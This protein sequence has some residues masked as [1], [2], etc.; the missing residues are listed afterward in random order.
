M[1]LDA[2][3]T[4]LPPNIQSLEYL[5][6]VNL[7]CFHSTKHS[8]QKFLDVSRGKCAVSEQAICLK[9]EKNEIMSGTHGSKTYK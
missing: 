9:G 8:L 1:L 3:R 2:N 5:P 6:V 7:I 4:F